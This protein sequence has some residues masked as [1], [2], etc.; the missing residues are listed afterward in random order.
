LPL[1]A[2]CTE[3]KVQRQMRAG[4]ERWQFSRVA[5]P[6]LNPKD[7]ARLAADVT[8]RSNDVSKTRN[9]HGYW[10]DASGNLV[11]V[12]KTKAIDR[13]RSKVM[14]E[15]CE[16]AKAARASLLGFKTTAMHGVNAFVARSLQAYRA[17]LQTKPVR[18]PPCA[19]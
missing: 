19:L 1:H 17:I 9:P 13:D 8:Q 6:Q 4:F 11:P 18:R 12:S 14:A 5:A 3:H 10:E 7:V 15:L 2:L 16:Q